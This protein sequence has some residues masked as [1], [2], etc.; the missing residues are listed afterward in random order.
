MA[1]TSGADRISLIALWDGKP[2]G[3]AA[4]GTAQ[5]VQLARE[6]GTIRIEL[7]DANQLLQ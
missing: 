1:E 6:T 3:D 7:V 2:S 5:L 4:G